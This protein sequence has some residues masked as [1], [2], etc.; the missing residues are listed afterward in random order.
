MHVD[1]D[2][3]R[4]AVE[5]SYRSMPLSTTSWPNPHADSREATLE[6]YSRLTGPARYRIV[7]ARAE[8]WVRA[9]AALGLADT[10]PAQ[11]PS[12]SGSSGAHAVWLHPRA[13]R[14]QPLLVV[15][16]PLEDVPDCIVTLGA[17]EPATELDTQPDCACDACDYGA[18]DLL[19]A[20]DDMF[21]AIVA[22]DFVYAS[23]HGWSLHTTVDGWS[24]RG[25]VHFRDIDVMVAAARAGKSVGTHTLR[26]VP[27]WTDLH[28]GPPPGGSAS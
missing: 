20:V 8:A 5:S 22:A 7:G 25:N 23:G 14:A 6:E 27:W 18:V 4:D 13:D 11:P 19:S 24:A 21:I 1:L 16:R 3:L 12:W 17:G 10:A 15:R 9:L 2:A 26:G 28:D